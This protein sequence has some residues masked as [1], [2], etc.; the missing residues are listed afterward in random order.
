LR[1]PVYAARL[2]DRVGA[3][4]HVIDQLGEDDSPLEQ[5]MIRYRYG[6]WDPAYYALLG[7]LIGRGLIEVIPLSR[8]FGYRTTERGQLVAKRIGGD[9]SYANVV[10]RAT[11]LRRWLDKQGSTL[12]DWIYEE[13]PEVSKANWHAEL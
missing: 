9:D 12:K 3:P 13:V 6:P 11:Y 4:Q 7:S 1:Y 8:G 5:R 10:E 2:L